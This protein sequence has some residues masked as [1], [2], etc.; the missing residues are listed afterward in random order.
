MPVSRSR[1]EQF[2][3]LV[4][5]AVSR[6]RDRLPERLADVEI[7]IDDV[8]APG[9]DVRLADA[10][11]AGADGPARIVIYR[12]PV[13]TRV[14]GER[15]RAALVNDVLVEELA[16]LLGVDPETLDPDYGRD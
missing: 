15:M 12:R 2:D 3:D 11:A 8:P 7:L 16:A 13:E 4:Q 1:A 5:E 14:L 6:L 9:G 10:A